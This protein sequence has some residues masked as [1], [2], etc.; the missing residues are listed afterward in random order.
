M[1]GLLSSLAHTGDLTTEQLEKVRRAWRVGNDMDIVRSKFN[2]DMKRGDI[3]RCRDGIWLN[4]E[5]RGGCA[6]ICRGMRIELWKRFGYGV[7]ILSLLL[8]IS[9]NE[10]HARC[11]ASIR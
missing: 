10:S 8:Q 9:C 3:R 11:C 1:L 5:V 2:V 6:C 7:C 4:D